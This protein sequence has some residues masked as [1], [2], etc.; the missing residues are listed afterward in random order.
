MS[1]LFY[2]QKLIERGAW[3]FAPFSWL[4]ACGVFCRNWLYDHKWL[5]ISKVPSV[6]V[7]VGNIVA[8]GT[9]KTPFVH[10][11]AKRFAHRKVAI[12]SRGYGSDEP[13]L[14]ANRLPNVKVYVGKDRAALAKKA[15]ADLLILDDGFQHRRLHRDFDIVLEGEKT[16]YLP[17]GFL[18]DSPKRLKSANA[19]FKI[20]DLK[21]KVVRILDSKKQEIPSIRG[22]KV[23][24]FCGIANPK[25]FKKTVEDLGAEIIAEKIFGDHE[26]ADLAKLPKASALICTEKDFVKLPPTDLPIYYLEVEMEVVDRNKWEKLIEKIDQKIDN[27]PTYDR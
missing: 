27:R 17:W 26:P 15:E 3:Y 16:H 6:V 25:R 20:G 12:L 24:I 9:G 1:L 8:G 21:L 2:G 10:M 13:I 11:L 23:A 14:L 4:Y 5:S 18:R 7:S 19:V 22:W